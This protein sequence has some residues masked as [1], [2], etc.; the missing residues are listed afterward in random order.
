MAELVE[1]AAQGALS[2]SVLETSEVN[3][4]LLK[5]LTEIDTFV[6]TETPA[7]TTAAWV[8]LQF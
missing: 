8:K 6:L 1:A 7:S 4:R 5:Q 2:R 3:H